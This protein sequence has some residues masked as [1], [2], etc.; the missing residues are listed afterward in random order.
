MKQALS[1][2]SLAFVPKTKG[3]KLHE[4]CEVQAA[5]FVQIEKPKARPR[6]SK[7]LTL[8]PALQGPHHQNW[9]LYS[10]ACTAVLPPTSL[11]PVTTTLPSS[12][13]IGHLF[14]AASAFN[15]PWNAERKTPQLSVQKA[16]RDQYTFNM[17]L[18]LTVAKAEKRSG[19]LLAESNQGESRARV[20][21]VRTSRT[22]CLGRHQYSGV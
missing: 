8:I 1:E 7:R 12:H 20:A 5:Q 13:S 21:F 3:A 15:P 18:L 11:Q 16:N 9:V 10:T 19:A 2:K 22:G 4:S 14:Q 6:A 17:E